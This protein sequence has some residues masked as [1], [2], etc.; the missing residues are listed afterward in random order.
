MEQCF[1]CGKRC[2][3]LVYKNA[4]CNK[5]YLCKFCGNMIPIKEKTSVEVSEIWNNVRN[6][7]DGYFDKRETYLNEAAS[8]VYNIYRK[9]F[10]KKTSVFDVGCGYGNLLNI[11]KKRG[12]N[13][14]GIETDASTLNQHIKY[15][16][17]THIGSIEQYNING[18]YDIFMFNYS[19]YFI[20]DI[21]KVMGKI[22]RCMNKDGIVCITIADLWTYKNNDSPGKSHAFYP[23]IYSLVK[24][25]EICGFIVISIKKYKDSYYTVFGIDNK[26]DYTVKGINKYIYYY[27]YFLIK[28]KQMRFK[29]FGSVY[30]FIRKLFI[31]FIKKQ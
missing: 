2:L 7:D 4:G 11:L 16:L 27:I 25:M 17:K 30:N 15:G 28:S 14:C 22:K 3:T 21:V 6:S 29:I 20:T 26:N 19:I 31:W 13:V 8:I 1:I 10:E 24:L 18:N 9:F 23:N 5:W 12:F